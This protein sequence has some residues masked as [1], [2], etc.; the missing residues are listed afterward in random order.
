M[1]ELSRESIHFTRD[2]IPYVPSVTRT[3]VTTGAVRGMA[4]L[5]APEV[6]GVFS[7]QAAVP[8]MSRAP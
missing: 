4:A 8:M 3:E 1:P 2:A 5:S 7:T 6:A